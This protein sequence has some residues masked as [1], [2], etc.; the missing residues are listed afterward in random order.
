MG[1]SA[2]LGYAVGRVLTCVLVLALAGCTGSSPAAGTRTRSTPSSELVVPS[3]VSP[4]PSAQPIQSS[5][6]PASSAQTAALFVP[7]P[8]GLPAVVD[9]GPRDSPRVALTF[10]ADMTPLMLRR[11]D[12]G[13]VASYYNEALI[14]ELRR[15]RVPAT[16][17]LTGL[18]MQRYP[19]VTRQLAADP[20]FE[21]G[22][23]TWQHRAFTADCY[24]LAQVPASEMLEEVT[25]AQQMLDELA[26][27]RATRLFR[28]PGGCYDEAA[29]R[30]IA[31]S[32]MTVIQFDVA[33]GDGF[34]HQPDAIVR[35]VLG[36][37]RNGSI[38]V[39]HMNGGN[40]SPRTADAIGP[41]VDRLRARGYVLTTV[42][43]LFSS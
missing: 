26:G 10:D 12:T 3:T 4:T 30:A 7:G 34:Q 32:G 19:D 20:L 36:G 23:H 27:S 1:A 15:L 11:L 2:C 35:T 14:E 9:A 22:T 43:G 25:Q 31:P 42:T 37:V 5:G 40:T 8:D 39:L 28:F 24:G 6:P 29:L 18:W 13:E 17:F 21:L 41:I 38:V 33:A 16:L